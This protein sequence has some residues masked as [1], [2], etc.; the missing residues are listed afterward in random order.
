METKLLEVLD[1]L[2]NFHH[3][4]GGKDK[5]EKDKKEKDKYTTQYKERA[6]NFR[7]KAGKWEM[8]ST[9]NIANVQQYVDSCHSALKKA[10]NDIEQSLE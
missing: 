3:N 1:F 9:G 7:D 6:T 10:G 2:D 5:Q 8:E 4:K